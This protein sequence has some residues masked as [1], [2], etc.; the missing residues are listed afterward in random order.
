MKILSAEQTRQLDAYTI[1]H[2]P[3]HSIELMERASLTFCDWFCEHFEIEDRPVAI[4]CGPGNNGGDGLAIGRILQYRFSDVHIFHCQ[5][6]DQA[7]ED[8]LINLK[9]LPL[10]AGLTYQLLQEGADFPAISKG[11][12]IIDA[13]FGSGLNRPVEG[14]WAQL[15]THLNNC[16]NKRISVDIPSGVFADRPTTGMAIQAHH[17]FSFELPKLAF[18]LPENHKLVGQ[19]EVR[20]IGLHPVFLAKAQTPHALTTLENVQAIYR[21]RSKFDHKGSNGKALLICGSLGM[22]GAAILATRA[23]LHTG[24]GLVSVQVPKR[25]YEIMQIAIPEAM[26]VLDQHEEVFTKVPDV[27]GFQSVGIGCGLGKAVQ[28]EHALIELLA[29]SNL[30]MVIDADALNLLASM[31]KGISYL[32]EGSIITPHPKEFERLFGESRNDFHRL[33]V[34]KTNAKKWGIYIVLKGAHTAIGCPD[35]RVFFNASGNPGMATAGS[36]DV[37]TG[38]L[39]S[40]LAQGYTPLESARLGVF[41]HGLAGD[42]A[43]REKEEEAMLASDIIEH[44]GKAYQ[45]IKKRK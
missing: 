31:E 19:W 8:F 37:L 20:S 18:L 42:L 15:I 17:T 12:I 4:F 36:G 43:A 1:K 5:I 34:L 35:G 25:L 9:R 2:E 44:I 13:I 14:Y 6:S 28:S 41:L 26:V 40:L 21:P 45:Q 16:S 30:P 24:V 32:P 22:A 29:N 7:S 11:T 38:I 27:R 33:D 3:I 10:Q 39:S 23:C